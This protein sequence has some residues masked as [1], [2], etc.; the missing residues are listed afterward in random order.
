MDVTGKN[1]DYNGGPAM[2]RKAFE[3][4]MEGRWNLE[5]E[6]QTT[7]AEQGATIPVGPGSKMSEILSNKFG[8]VVDGYVAFRIK[9]F[10]NTYSKEE[11]IT[12]TQ[13][14]Q[15]LSLG[16]RNG[17]MKEYGL[18]DNTQVEHVLKSMYGGARRKEGN[19]TPG[20]EVVGQMAELLANKAK[21]ESNYATSKLTNKEIFAGGGEGFVGL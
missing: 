14:W 18:S 4:W 13:R 8:H 17:L 5:T 6:F 15:I 2:W 21:G 3:R 9:E 20:N 10:Y 7:A 16:L 1:K 12:D 11:T 19:P